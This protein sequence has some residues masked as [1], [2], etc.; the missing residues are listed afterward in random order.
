METIN[1]KSCDRI[2]LKERESN[3]SYQSI[4]NA[5]Q[6]LDEILPYGEIQYKANGFDNNWIE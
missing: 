2:F 3:W 6:F 5:R 4:L 1:L